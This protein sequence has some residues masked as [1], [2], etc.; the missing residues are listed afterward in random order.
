MSGIRAPSKLFHIP[1]HIATLAAPMIAKQEGISHQQAVFRMWEHQALTKRV[2]ARR[3]V[4]K[5]DKETRLK[6]RLGFPIRKGIL[7]S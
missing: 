4:F 7:N 2:L 6:S 1:G 5:A 3:E